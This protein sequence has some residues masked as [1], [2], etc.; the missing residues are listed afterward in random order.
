MICIMAEGDIEPQ[1][2]DSL[3]SCWIEL[4]RPWKACNRLLWRIYTYRNELRKET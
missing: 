2:N 3:Q 4:V 1:V